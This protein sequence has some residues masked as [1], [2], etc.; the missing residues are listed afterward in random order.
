[1]TFFSRMALHAPQSA[2]IHIGLANA[3]MNSDQPGNALAEY[4]KAYELSRSQPDEKTTAEQAFSAGIQGKA[5]VRLIIANYYAAA[6]LAGM[7][8]AYRMM[9]EPDNAIDSYKLA[10]GQ[11][12]FD[13]TIYLKLARVYEST[14]R[15]NDAIASYERALQLDKNLKEAASSIQIASA[16]KEVFDQARNV[17]LEALSS[18]QQ[19][20]PDALYGEA[21]MLLLSGKKEAGIG[22]LGEVIQKAPL[23]YG[24]NLALGKFHSERG[25]YEAAFGNFSAAF[26]AEPTS[27][28]AA[29]E[30]AITTLALG[31]TLTAEMWASKAYELDHSGYYEESLESIK[32]RAEENRTNR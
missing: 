22:L 24:A 30:L 20:S 16:E 18:K 4:G 28:M 5:K 7:G 25:E 19:D 13:A 32:R 14:G 26:A 23:H 29:H 15:F 6:A 12:A 8:D 27:A 31:D 10:L 2:R 21:I 11:N 9:G 17:Y 3:L 1:M